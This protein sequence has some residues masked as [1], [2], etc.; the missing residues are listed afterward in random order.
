M[1]LHEN[2]SLLDPFNHSKLDHEKISNYDFIKNNS[3]KKRGKVMIDQTF[4]TLVVVDGKF[5]EENAF[6]KVLEKI[7]EIRKIISY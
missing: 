3:T 4:C 1:T 5:L 7:D 6:K 2:V